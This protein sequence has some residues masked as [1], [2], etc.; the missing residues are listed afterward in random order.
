MLGYQG[1]TYTQQED[2]AKVGPVRVTKEEN[3]TIPL[4]PVLAFGAMAAG[5]IL[6]FAAM[7][8]NH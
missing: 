4:P 7:R 3:K 8:R 1:I 2:V 5:A 6:I